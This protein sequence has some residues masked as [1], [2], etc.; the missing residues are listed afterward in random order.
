MS[1]AALQEYIRVSKY[2]RFVPGLKRRENW[3]EQVSRVMNMH[4]EKYKNLLPEIE[5]DIKFAEDLFLRKRI[6]GSQ[7]ALQFGGQPILKKHERMYNCGFTYCDRPKFF[8]EYM[9]LLLCGVGV[10]FSVQT[11]H[12]AKMQPI[13]APSKIKKS[14]VIPDSIEGWADAVGV[15]MSAYFIKDNPFPEY[16]DRT[17]EFDYSQIRPKGAKLSHGAKAPGPEPLQRAIE[18]VRKV[19][20]DVVL[21][22]ESIKTSL[23]TYLRPI[24][25]YDINMHLADAVI[26]G[27][28]R[29]SATIALFTPTDESMAKAKT[30]DWFIKNP[31][32]GRS[33]NSAVLVRDKVD[34]DSFQALMKSV[35][36]FG[37]PGFVFTA[38][39]EC[40]Y[41][42]CLE[43]GLYPVHEETGKT[44]VQFCNLSTLNLKKCKTEEEFYEMCRG[45]A[46]LGTLQAGYTDFPYLG[47]TTEFITKREALLGVSMTGMMDNPDIAFDPVIQRKGAQIVLDVNEEIAAKI[48]INKAAR[49]TALKPEG[50]SSCVLGTTSGIHPH[51]AKRYFRRVQANEL[52]VP[53]QHFVKYNPLAVEESVW[54]P[55]HVTKVIT[56]VCEVP[57]GA[58]TKTQVDA[59][60]LL[61]HVKLTQ[62]NWV[63]AGTRPE[64]MVKPWLSHNVSNTCHVRDDEWEEVTRFIFANREYF[65]G[66]SL[67]PI[68]GDKDYP[69]TPFTAILTDTEILKEYG[70]GSLLASGLIVDG[71]Y[72]FDN[73]LWAACDCVLGIGENLDKKE[74]E[75]MAS[76]YK[77]D[78]SHDFISGMLT[79]PL[80]LVPDEFHDILKLQE[81]KD[82]VRRAIQFA[83]RYFDGNLRLMAYCLKDV[84]NFKYWLDLKRTYID[85]PWEEL[86]EE[87]DS[88]KLEQTIACSGGQCE[89]V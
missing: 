5:A 89:L 30:G 49:A 52:E 64:C 34:Y 71:L 35:Q 60:T 11:H 61:E 47:K 58:K 21:T 29:R 20:N 14:F 79:F 86:R 45:A 7:R 87:E 44:G 9:Y 17:V 65:A 41:N 27:G 38:S 88:T 25:C 13:K 19:L 48:K 50:T 73:N 76:K 66:I 77:D 36:E 55:N 39:T 22:H 33:N 81:K 57:D 70:K 32:R 8:Q 54:D 59:L 69:Q 82:W 68:K 51:H 18:T 2:S 72:A 74:K 84:T 85:V 37:E 40:G 16:I 42:P 15:L 31:Q 10:G 23:F 83:D 26:S 12:V 63:A 67:L 3:D 24:H 78:L 43:I 62:Q 4:R 56:F 75:L 28:H 80:E 1:Q 46:I 6:L 53:L